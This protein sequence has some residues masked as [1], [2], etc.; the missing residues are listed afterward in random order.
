MEPPSLHGHLEAHVVAE[1]SC[2]CCIWPFRKRRKHHQPHEVTVTSDDKIKRIE[3]V[4]SNSV[5]T[6]DSP[7]TP[8]SE[9]KD[10]TSKRKG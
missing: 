7:M 6:S 2:N 9:K 5:S 1:D 8:P 3:V 4:F 10:A